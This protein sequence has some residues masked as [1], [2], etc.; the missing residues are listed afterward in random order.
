MSQSKTVLCFDGVP[1][2]LAWACL[3]SETAEK[4]LG[5]GRT[6]RPFRISACLSGF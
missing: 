3:R 1:V 4:S 6:G 5:V 2:E